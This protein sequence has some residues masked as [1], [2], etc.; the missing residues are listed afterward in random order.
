MAN[1]LNREVVELKSEL[2]VTKAENDRLRSAFAALKRKQ[3]SLD[4]QLQL[5][6][7][8][9]KTQAQKFRRE[10][11]QQH[12]APVPCGEEVQ[13]LKQELAATKK[14]LAKELISR[15]NLQNKC[16]RYKEQLDSVK[17]LQQEREDEQGDKGDSEKSHR[18][19]QQ[20]AELL[21]VVKK[22]M[23]LIDILKQQRAHAEAAV[24]LN[25]TE[26]DLMNE[27]HR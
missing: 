3:S 1:E 10:A 22:Q 8:R 19:E 27:V 18:L 21:L 16:N 12:P 23:R 14:D 6:S 4:S 9:H 24:L 15:Q 5:L 26:K 2:T 11:L 13:A 25:I 7:Q 20:R 17:R